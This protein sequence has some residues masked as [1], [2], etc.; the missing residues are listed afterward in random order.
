MVEDRLFHNG[1]AVGYAPVKAGA[2]GD[3]DAWVLTE[4][5]AGRQH[6]VMIS[7][8]IPALRSFGPVTVPE[9]SCFVMGDN[10]D[11]STDSRYFGFV[12]RD[13][14]VGRATAVAISVDL[15]RWCRPRWGRFLPRLP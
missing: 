1:M 4:D 2:P 8:R 14:I 10:R 7:P 5:L 12:G 11:N 9:G 15:E 6:P 13:R 3:P